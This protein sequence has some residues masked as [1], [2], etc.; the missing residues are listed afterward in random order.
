VL[1]MINILLLFRCTACGP[2]AA[3]P[4]PGARI[5]ALTPA[6]AWSPHCYETVPGALL[7]IVACIQI[8]MRATIS[9]L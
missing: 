9:T 6:N 1:G 7:G 3:S 2:C 8:F 5:V 4:L